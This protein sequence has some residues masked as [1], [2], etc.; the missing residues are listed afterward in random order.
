M[1]K[2]FCLIFLLINPNLNKIDSLRKESVKK[3]DPEI[4][5][6]IAYAFY[7][8]SQSDSSIIYC[9][10]ALNFIKKEPNKQLESDA[11]QQIGIVFLV[12]GQYY[13]ANEFYFKALSI[14]EKLP[15]KIKLANLFRKIGD[16]YS[17][18]LD[19]KTAHYYFKKSE[20]MLRLLYK[21]DEK[22][23][24]SLAVCLNNQ[25]NNFRRWKK[26]ELALKAYDISEPFYVKANPYQGR[27]NTLNNK[28]VCYS[29]MKEYKKAEK[30][31]LESYEGI[32][33]T[34]ME[35]NYRSTFLKNI[36][37]MY[38][39]SKNYNKSI[40]Y[41]LQCLKFARLYNYHKDELEA[42]G[43]VS[44]S[45]QALTHIEKALYYK[46]MYI[47]VDENFRKEEK[48]KLIK[49][50]SLVHKTEVQDQD[51]VLKS[52]EI[53]N[54]RIQILSG[55]VGIISLCVFGFFL[56]QN[57]KKILKQ[58]SKITDQKNKIEVFS[59]ELKKLNDGL[60]KEVQKRTLDLKIANERLVLMNDELAGS[61]LKGRTIERGRISASLHDNVGGQIAALKWNLQAIDL[62]N[63]N[64]QNAKIFSIIS[65]GLKNAY[66]DVRNISHNLIPELLKEKGLNEATRKLVENINFSSKIVFNFEVK[67]SSKLDKKH[68]LEAYS[69]IMELITNTI[70]HSN[71]T[72]TNLVFEY[73][74]DTLIID[75]TDNGTNF[76]PNQVG[77]GLKNISLMTEAANKKI[78]IK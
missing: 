11:L 59:K 61:I 62:E 28:G 67:G 5:L 27:V 8:N 32:L 41:G 66:Q 45:Y 76:S 73:K 31:L 51:L 6:K 17:L 78:L 68:E 39:E 4:D 2:F 3:Y 71:G 35:K 48:E 25:G 47:E 64:E 54:Q 7:F 56:W 30:C 37:K 77:L 22:A 52:Q 70:K 15:D 40:Q 24:M 57:R 18:I 55:L 13:T 49:N 26:Y 1:I 12:S 74:N 43:F 60:E 20:K 33:N 63:L 50:L 16:S 23:L 21:T 34:D 58:S 44:N 75:Y 19:C 42:L 14:Q 9:Q 38:F 69:I 10:K 36:S 29:E 53:R 65:E 72:L 46:N